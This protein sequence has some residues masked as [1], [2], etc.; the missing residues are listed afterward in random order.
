MTFL[1]G[2]F[3]L[4]VMY[5]IYR[6]FKKKGFED[7]LKNALVRN[8]FSN[9]YKVYDMNGVGIHLVQDLTKARMGLI[10]EHSPNFITNI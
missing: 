7:N 4:A 9:Q 2:I 1:M 10:N 5:I 8:N 3:V 6:I